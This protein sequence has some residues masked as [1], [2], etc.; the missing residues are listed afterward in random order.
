MSNQKEKEETVQDEDGVAC[1]SRG[2]SGR[3]DRRFLL[4]PSDSN[5][6]SIKITYHDEKEK[7]RW[8]GGEKKGKE[9]GQYAAS[10][11]LCI[12]GS[13]DPIALAVEQSEIPSNR[14]VIILIPWI[15]KIDYTNLCIYH[16]SERE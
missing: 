3:K 13:K 8:E 14:T 16:I 6:Q 15:L 1:Q 7:M 2:T 10:S 9:G 4:D 5:R 12:R 11:D